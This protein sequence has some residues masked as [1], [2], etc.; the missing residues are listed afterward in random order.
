MTTM[1]LSESAAK[2]LPTALAAS[3]ATT[4]AVR[5]F[6]D[7]PGVLRVAVPRVRQHSRSPKCD[8]RHTL[9]WPKEGHK[10]HP[11]SKLPSRLAGRFASSEGRTRGEVTAGVQSRCAAL[12]SRPAPNFLSRPPAIFLKKREATPRWVLRCFSSSL[13]SHATWITRRSP[14]YGK[15]PWKEL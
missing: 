9:R 15:W 7:A 13:V 4:H 12:R 10:C 6:M 14:S 8:E 5:I 2:A 11:P 1:A 3:A